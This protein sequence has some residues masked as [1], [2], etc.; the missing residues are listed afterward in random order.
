VFTAVPASNF[1]QSSW[2]CCLTHKVIYQVNLHVD[3]TS[4]NDND[5]NLEK[6]MAGFCTRELAQKRDFIRLLP[7]IR[8]NYCLFYTCSEVHRKGK[9]NKKSSYFSRLFE[10]LFTH[11]NANADMGITFS[12]ASG[13]MANHF[14][15]PA[16]RTSSR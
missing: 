15:A 14:A 12:S 3:G 13:A 11:A 1:G 6:I 7:L 2:D 9:N 5:D 16:G 8:P 10:P 4:V